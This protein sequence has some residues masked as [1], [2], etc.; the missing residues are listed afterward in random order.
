ML[1][2][3][4]PANHESSRDPAQ[5]VPAQPLLPSDD[6]QGVSIEISFDSYANNTDVSATR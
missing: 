3:K 5:D 6:W 2:F 1:S 4:H